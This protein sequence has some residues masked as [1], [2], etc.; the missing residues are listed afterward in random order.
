MTADAPL[1]AMNAAAQPRCRAVSGAQGFCQ[2]CFD[3]AEREQLNIASLTQKS[4][5]LAQLVAQPKWRQ[6]LLECLMSC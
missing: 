4:A 1:Q 2:I 5:K 6:C 3:A